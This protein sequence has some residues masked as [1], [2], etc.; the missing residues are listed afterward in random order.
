MI[1]GNHKPKK[2][3][4]IKKIHMKQNDEYGKKPKNPMIMGR[5]I[6]C[7]RYTNNTETYKMNKPIQHFQKLA[8]LQ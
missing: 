3:P 8:T 5:L 2:R 7:I 1:V 4:T 6:H